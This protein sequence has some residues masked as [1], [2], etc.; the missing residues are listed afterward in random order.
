MKIKMGR[1]SSIALCLLTCA[2]PASGATVWDESVSGDLASDPATPTAVS[3]VTGSNVVVGDVNATSDIRDYFTFTIG[4]DQTLSAVT[5]LS[6]E[7]N[8]GFTAMNVGSSSFIPGFT[9]MLDFLG[10]THTDASLIGE[11]LLPLLGSGSLGGA[12]FTPPLGPGTYS[13][14]IQQT[15]GELTSYALDFEVSPVPAPAAVWLL[16]SAL[17]GVAGWRRFR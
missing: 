1:V 4:S 17:I 8:L 14:V 9:T 13:Y 6:Y 15:S 2:F 10:G 11:L 5:L 16:G 3:F 7:G 12:G